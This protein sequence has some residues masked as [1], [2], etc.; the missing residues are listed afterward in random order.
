MLGD[1]HSSSTSLDDFTELLEH[2][3]HT[4]EVD[5]QDRVDACLLG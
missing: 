1:D 5:L 3:G 2:Q 4:D